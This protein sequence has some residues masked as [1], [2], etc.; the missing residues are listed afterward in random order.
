MAQKLDEYQLAE[1]E[2]MD[3]VYHK[4]KLPE[5]T[6]QAIVTGL[7]LGVVMVAF[8]VYMGLKTG[9]GEGGS[10]IAVILSYAIIVGVLKRPY[11][12]VENNICQTMAS[13]AGSIGN[14]VNVIPALFLLAASGMIPRAP[15]WV[16]ILLWCFF[17]S[18]L[19]VFFAIP[20]RQQIVV[21]EKLRF[22]TGTACAETIMALHTSTGGSGMV[23]AKM[24]TVV[25]AISGIVAWF[26]NGVPV[27]LPS[28]VNFSGKWL[29]HS[30][31]SLTMGIA[32]SPMM[33]GVGFLVGI[34]IGLSMLIGSLICWLICAPLLFDAGIL[35]EIYSFMG[36]AGELKEIQ[37][38]IVVKW[39]MWPGLGIMVSA[40]VMNT[41]LQWKVIGRAFKSMLG[42]AKYSTAATKLDVP[43]K[44][45]LGGFMFATTGVI[46]MLYFRFDV[47]VWV[48]LLI[49]PVSFLLSTIAVRATGETDINP[50]GAMGS[51]TQIAYGSVHPGHIT[52]NL[53]AGGVSSSGASEAADMMQDLKTGYLLGATPRLQVYAQ[54]IGVA[55]GALICVPVF[56]LLVGADGGNIG[57]EAMPAPAAITWEGLARMVSIGPRALP[58]FA[59]YAL[60]IGCGVGSLIVIL[61]KY[62]PKIK[63]FLPSAVALG[64][65]MVVPAIYAVSI[66]IGALIMWLVT[67]IHKKWI[68]EYAASIGAGSIVGEGLI[69]VIGAAAALLWVKLQVAWPALSQLLQKLENGF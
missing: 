53:L 24:L 7:L 52:A 18:F 67:K 9:W 43:F 31:K 29:G 68:T 5:F 22:P 6:K 60:L 21:I 25:A 28:A 51:I 26:Q 66:F 54:F 58:R 35:Q 8:N 48:G 4:G 1:K 49:I 69:G 30:Y 44:W 61:E 16:D 20:L 10:L 19:G 11:S 45:L 39:T 38:P 57:T 15:N 13:A 37:Y 64:V 12:V 56:F 50:V 62:A 3:N 34:R 47:P 40:G 17:T 14:I 33:V 46:S 59:I 55:V 41:L 23:K 65:A 27:L 32:L 2:W 42:S 36:K 63:P